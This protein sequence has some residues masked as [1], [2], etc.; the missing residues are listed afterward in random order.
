[1]TATLSQAK[2]FSGPAVLMIC[3]SLSSRGEEQTL[4]SIIISS[5]PDCKTQSNSFAGCIC[6]SLSFLLVSDLKRQILSV[7][8]SLVDQMMSPV[9]WIQSTQ[10]PTLSFHCPRSE[11]LQDLKVS[12]LFLV[13]FNRLQHIKPPPEILA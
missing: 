12:G 10:F 11:N 1:M 8:L 5:S 9:C 13:P 7:A 4:I 2:F 3:I 6:I